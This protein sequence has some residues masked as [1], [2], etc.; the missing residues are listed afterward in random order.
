MQVKNFKVLDM[1]VSG[2]LLLLLGMSLALIGTLG[3]PLCI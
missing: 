1:R 2:A 3:V